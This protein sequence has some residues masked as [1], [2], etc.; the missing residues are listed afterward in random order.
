MFAL[1]VYYK[2]VCDTLLDIISRK[3]WKLNKL[4]KTKVINKLGVMAN[5]ACEESMVLQDSSF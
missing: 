5:K 4:K 3:V 2:M 1:R